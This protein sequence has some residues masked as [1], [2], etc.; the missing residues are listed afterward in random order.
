MEHF[1]NK[2][3]LRVVI[4]PVLGAGGVEGK[5]YRTI[6]AA[7]R[8]LSCMYGSR[9]AFTIVTAPL[10]VIDHL[11]ECDALFIGCLGGRGGI[12][13][14][15]P[16]TPDELECVSKEW[17]IRVFPLFDRRNMYEMKWLDMLYSRHFYD[18]IDYAGFSGKT[19]YKALFSRPRCDKEAKEYYFGTYMEEPGCS[20][21]VSEITVSTDVDIIVKTALN[22]PEWFPYGPA[23][24]TVR[25]LVTERS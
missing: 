16:A 25:S 23:S 7:I 15:V 1:R 5:R 14:G 24:F 3:V 12:S 11:F 19:L 10:L 22:L 17:G 20:E 18:G 8:D 13:N 4:A 2:P 9:L 21:P 6:S